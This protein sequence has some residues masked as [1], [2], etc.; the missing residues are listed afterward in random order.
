MSYE[1]KHTIEFE[2]RMAAERA[3]DIANGEAEGSV[4]V[5]FM[6]AQDVRDHYDG[7]EDAL[8]MLD[9]ASDEDIEAAIAGAEDAFYERWHEMCRN[10]VLELEA[11]YNRTD[12][13]AS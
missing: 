12:R 4:F 5:L 6:R 9:I 3:R 11:K 8:E 13:D 2:D 7:D 1:V 10:A